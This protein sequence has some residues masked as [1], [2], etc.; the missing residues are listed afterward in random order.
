MDCWQV[1]GGAFTPKSPFEVPKI[2]FIYVKRAKDKNIA[3]LFIGFHE[4]EMDNASNFMRGF[5][6]DSNPKRGNEM[7][8][9]FML[10]GSRLSTVLYRTLGIPEYGIANASNVKRGSTPDSNPKRGNK[11]M[12]KKIDINLCKSANAKTTVS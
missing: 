10:K 11:K 7:G 6:P 8:L 9:L 12:R 3:K 4:Y 2:L 1:W 5:T